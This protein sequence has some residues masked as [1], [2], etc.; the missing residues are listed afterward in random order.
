MLTTRCPCIKHTLVL[1]FLFAC[2]HPSQDEAPIPDQ[3]EAPIPAPLKPRDARRALVGTWQLLVGPDTASGASDS[4]PWKAATFRIAD[5]LISGSRPEVKAVLTPPFCDLVDLA[6]GSWALD[7]PVPVV[8]GGTAVA[9]NRRKRRW[10][11]DLSPNL[12]DVS[13]GLNGQFRGDS[14][15]G[16]WSQY[17]MGTLAR[18]GRFVMLRMETRE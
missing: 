10:E 13:L 15:V 17:V 12:F 4:V 7:G 18:S 16:T 1:L 11:I 8:F 2:A 6:S 3:D 14:L 5:T 9:L